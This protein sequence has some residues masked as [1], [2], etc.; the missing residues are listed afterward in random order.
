MR[1]SGI[2]LSMAL[3]GIVGVLFSL[4]IN[5]TDSQDAYGEGIFNNFSEEYGI[6][7]VQLENSSDRAIEVGADI[8]GDLQE[9]DEIGLVTIGGA[10][11]DAVKASLNVENLNIFQSLMTTIGAKVKLSPAMQA[12]IYGVIVI[13][14]LFTVIGAILRWKT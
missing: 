9:E 6:T 5:D 4:I 7:L 1:L 8:Q 12:I 10:T 14:I 2:L 3:I 13:I 11:V